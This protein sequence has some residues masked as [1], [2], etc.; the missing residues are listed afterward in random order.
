MSITKDKYLH[1]LSALRA[2]LDEVT[3]AFFDTL[4][5]DNV[6]VV[7]PTELFCEQ[8]CV[9]H[10]QVWSYFS[11]GHHITSYSIPYLVERFKEKFGKVGL[12]YSF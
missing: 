3:V 4:I 8:R 7:H 5:D 12:R 6:L 2:K 10:D 1:S 11:D 9:L